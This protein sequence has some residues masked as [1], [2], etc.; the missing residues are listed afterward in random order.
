MSGS[1]KLVEKNTTYDSHLY[2]KVKRKLREVSTF[3]YVSNDNIKCGNNTTDSLIRMITVNSM[4]NSVYE[5]K[6]VKNYNLKFKNFLGTITEY[7]ESTFYK[8]I[9]RGFF[10]RV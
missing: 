10:C 7:M 8:F 4:L 9:H 6:L 2:E 3:T 1:E 5:K